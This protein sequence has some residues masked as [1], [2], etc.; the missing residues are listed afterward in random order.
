MAMSRTR[1]IAAS[2]RSVWVTALLKGGTKMKHRILV[3]VGLLTVAGILCFGSAASV[4]KANHWGFSNEDLSGVYI[5]Q[6]TGTYFLLA[7]GSPYAAMNGPFAANGTIW[8][9][10]QG[11]MKKNLIVNYNG[12]VFHINNAMSTYQVNPDGTFTEEFKHLSFI[13][14]A[15]LQYDGVLVKNG[16]E[17][18]LIVSDFLKDGESIGNIGMVISGSMIRQGE[19]SDDD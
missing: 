15:T 5:V 3:I 11:N 2:V 16:K 18:R 13:G 14:P 6:L 12:H 1:Q 10:G 8:A 7:P 19:R 9:D 4:S 17:A